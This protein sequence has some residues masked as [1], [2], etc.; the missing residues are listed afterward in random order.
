MLVFIVFADSKL[1]NFIEKK[2]K[3]KLISFSEV[4]CVSEYGPFLYLV[5]FNIS[6]RCKLDI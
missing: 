5:Y 1:T 2:E 4:H 6:P 3:V